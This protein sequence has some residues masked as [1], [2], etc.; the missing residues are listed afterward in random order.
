MRN[1]VHPF[2]IMGLI[3]A[4]VVTW[5]ASY[6][7]RAESRSGEEVVVAV[8]EVVDDDLYA[9]AD[10]IVID[11]TIKGDLIAFGRV[12]LI[13]GT[14]EGD[15]IG[16]AQAI[17]VRGIVRDDVR[18]A[19]QA[20]VVEKGGLIGDDINVGA[21]GVALQAGSE[22]GGNMWAAASQVSSA[23]RLAGDL[24]GG[25]QSVHIAGSV[26]GDVELLVGDGE[27]E[28]DFP[29]ELVMPPLPEGFELPRIP[30]GLSVTPE[31]RVAGRLSYASRF[32]VVV[33]EGVV[34]GEV[35]HRPP[36][37]VE[38]ETQPP[39]EF[40]S[41][42]WAIDQGQRLLRLILVGLLVVW[43]ASRGLYHTTAALWTRPLSSLGWGILSPF[44][45][46]LFLIVAGLVILGVAALLSYILGSTA[47]LTLLLSAATGTIVVIY[48]M[49]VLYIGA[50]ITAFALSKRIF[51]TRTVHPV[52]LMLLGI[53]ILWVLTAIPVVGV[54]IGIV[55]VLFGLGAIWLAVRRIGVVEAEALG[56]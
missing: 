25:A 17:A 51:R 38:E 10:R 27:A 15:L 35:I 19:A 22:V 46:L 9:A 36:E 28:P 7:A 42:A 52:W 1:R 47:L 26:G 50:L 12:V 39:A 44:A 45:M 21:Y 5:S 30:N 49:L 48:L 33:P 32:P 40:G 6:P 8:G 54:F 41:P 31:A 53:V 23:G 4:L 18:A 55:F 11:G 16:F 3:V 14:V 56:T 37:I 43:L 24:V 29:L 13:N 34:R 2:W 20:F